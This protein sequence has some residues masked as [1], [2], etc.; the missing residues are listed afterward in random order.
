M[1][2]DIVTRGRREAQLAGR[3]RERMIAKSSDK[4]VVGKT[5]PSLLV[6]ERTTDESCRPSWPGGAAKMFALNTLSLAGSTAG[7]VGGASCVCV[8]VCV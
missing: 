7:R 4:K 2:D 8:C 3:E 1:P 6:L 5:Q